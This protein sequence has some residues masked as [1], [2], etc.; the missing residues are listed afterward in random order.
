MLVE[1]GVSVADNFHISKDLFTS[2]VGL[3][4]NNFMILNLYSVT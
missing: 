1:K 3:L 2:L 4:D